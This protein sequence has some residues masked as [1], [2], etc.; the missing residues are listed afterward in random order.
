[1]RAVVQV[2]HLCFAATVTPDQRPNLSPKG[3]I[4]VWGDE[5]LFFLDIAS[6]NTRANL[7]VNP[8]IELNVVDQLSRRGY[9]FLGRATYHRE[10]AIYDEAVQRVFAE[11]GQTYS[12]TGVVLV[13]VERAEPLVSP[14]YWHVATEREMRAAWKVRRAALDEAFE[15]HI[16]SVPPFVVSADRGD[17]PPPEGV[18]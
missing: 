11:E 10:G 7:A 3:T 6:P 5:H 14:G 17:A 4:R 1:M 13:K 12:V 2:A 8:W 18:G 9:R 15:Q 16:A